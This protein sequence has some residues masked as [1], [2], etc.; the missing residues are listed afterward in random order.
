MLAAGAAVDAVERVMRGTHTTALALVRPPGHHAERGHAMGFCLFNNVA[1]AAA[2][3]RA[4]GAVARRHRRLGRAPR[5]RHAAHVR[6]D[7]NVLY[8]STHQYPVL[9]RHRAPTSCGW[10]RARGPTVNVPLPAG[11]TDDDY[12]VV[13][14]EWSSRSLA[15]S[16]PTSCWSPRASTRTSATRSR[17]CA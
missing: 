16:R 6:A 1:V 13:F 11:A 10:R 5:Q 12:R 3:A 14:D 17:R 8:M 9:S 4:R 15:R 2:H 7:P